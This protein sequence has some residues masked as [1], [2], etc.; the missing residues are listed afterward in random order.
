MNRRGSALLVTMVI[1]G[2][3]GMTLAGLGRMVALH[4]QVSGSLEDSTIAFAAAEAGIEEGLV[5]WR[6]NRDIEVPDLPDGTEMQESV[7]MANRVNLTT[8]ETT[9]GTG[10]GLNI[11]ST[12]PDSRYDLRIWYKAPEVGTLADLGSATYPYR[13]AKDETLDMDITN[14]GGETISFTYQLGAGETGCALIEAKVFQEDAN[15]NL[16]EEKTVTSQAS[17]N[18]VVLSISSGAQKYRLRIKP[19]IFA[20]CDSRAPAADSSYINY[21]MSVANLSENRADKLLDTGVSV[22]ESTGYYGSAKRTLRALVDRRTG[23]ILSLYDYTLFAQSG[24]E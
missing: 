17:E 19:F 16:L 3:I 11:P 18:N 22:V 14:L 20:T 5:R 8:G 2:V 10:I 13:L 7:P 15:G 12:S 9:S 21:F 23:T 6:F 4:L 1:T 24:I